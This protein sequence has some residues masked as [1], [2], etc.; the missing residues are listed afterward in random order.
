MF[1]QV[2]STQFR[3]VN[4]ILYLLAYNDQL[5]WVELLLLDFIRVCDRGADWNQLSI[6]NLD[7]SF[8]RLEKVQLHRRLRIWNYTQCTMMMMMMI[9]LTGAMTDNDDRR[10]VE[11]DDN[12][13][14]YKIDQKMSTD[15][16]GWKC[17]AMELSRVRGGYPRTLIWLRDKT[18]SNVLK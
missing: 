18:G 16:N 4:C 3:I 5:V 11:D 15:V 14:D 2:S 7:Q 6:F 1:Y 12:N 9:T 10:Q 17:A 8:P 13:S